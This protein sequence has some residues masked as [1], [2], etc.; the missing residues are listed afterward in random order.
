MKR[1]ILVVEDNQLN[2]ELLCDWLETEGYDAV[3]ASNLCEALAA[4]EKFIP[5]AVLLD[6]QLGADD[7]LSL[8]AWIRQ[9]TA[10]RHIPV[11]AVTAHAM[12]VDQERMLQAGCNACVS[13]PIVFQLLDHQLQRWLAHGTAAK[14]NHLPSEET[15]RATLCARC[16]KGDD[17]AE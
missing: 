9:Q 5:D 8:A 7:G 11:I 17:H 10:L 4:V 6:I 13:K 3:S 16:S 15:A 14:T 12:V 2:R 1:C